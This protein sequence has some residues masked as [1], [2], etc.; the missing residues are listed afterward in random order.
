MDCDD[1][2]LQTHGVV[3][4]ETREQTHA[5]CLE[6]VR[7]CTI[8]AMLDPNPNLRALFADSVP[9]WADRV[10]RYAPR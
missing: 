3:E 1:D 6:N 5:R 2:E 9:F 10:K 8:R 4:G 7:V